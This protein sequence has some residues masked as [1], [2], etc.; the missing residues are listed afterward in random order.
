[1]GSAAPGVTLGG[2]VSLEDDR[3]SGSSSVRRSQ[4]RLHQ[5]GSRK[6]DP[7]LLKAESKKATEGGFIFKPMKMQQI[8]EVA[9]RWQQAAGPTKTRLHKFPSLCSNSR[10]TGVTSWSFYSLHWL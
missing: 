1:M 4:G 3:A 5:R 7:V 2:T 6:T 8:L 9:K 10:P